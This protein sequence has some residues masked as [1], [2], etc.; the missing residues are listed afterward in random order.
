M[1]RFLSGNCLAESRTLP[2]VHCY[3]SSYES[4]L[5]GICSGK[6][7]EAFSIVSWFC[8]LEGSGKFLSL[9]EVNVSVSN[10]CFDTV[11]TQCFSF[12]YE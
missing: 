3:F 2:G 6:F 7:G 12:S 4:F 8:L 10:G 5:L 11:L 9:L 1:T